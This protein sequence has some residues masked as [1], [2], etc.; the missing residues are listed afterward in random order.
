MKKYNRGYVEIKSPDGNITKIL[1]DPNGLLYLIIL[2][3]IAHMMLIKW[4]CK[5][6]NLLKNLK[7]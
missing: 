2:A 5:G 4:G 1:L 7:E 6:L 3:S